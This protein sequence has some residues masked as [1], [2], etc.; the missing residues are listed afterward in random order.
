VGLGAI[1]TRAFGSD[2][3]KQPDQHSTPTDEY[4]W[5]QQATNRTKEDATSYYTSQRKGNKANLQWS[6]YTKDGGTNYYTIAELSSH[7]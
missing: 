4:N 6:Y 7:T 1:A 3:K 5:Y 2:N